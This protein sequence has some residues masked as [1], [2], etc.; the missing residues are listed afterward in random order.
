MPHSIPDC[1]PYGQLLMLIVAPTN[2]SQDL[3]S[4]ESKMESGPIFY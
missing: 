3:L 4:D 2:S 1:I